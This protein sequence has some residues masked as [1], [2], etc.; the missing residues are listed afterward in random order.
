M[1]AEPAG[2]LVNGRPGIGLGLLVALNPSVHLPLHVTFRLAQFAEPSGLII[3]RVEPRKIINE[4]KSQL[5]KR[6]GL[7]QKTS[8]EPSPQDHTAAAFHQ[9]ERRSEDCLVSAIENRLRG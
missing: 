3:E 7:R 2:H 6:F 1:V 9:I 5:S 8:R 4:R